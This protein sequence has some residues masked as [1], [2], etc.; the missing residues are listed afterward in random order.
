M[1]SAGLMNSCFTPS[2]SGSS[3]RGWMQSTGQTSTHAVSFVPMHGSKMM[4]AIFLMI[5]QTC[6]PALTGLF[7]P[8]VP[9]LGHYQ[10]CTRPEPLDALA[11]P[12]WRIENLE[13]LEAFGD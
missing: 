5:A 11:G 13:P 6:D 10:V 3:L 9:R 4:Y 2:W 12:G 7:T 8:A 1:H